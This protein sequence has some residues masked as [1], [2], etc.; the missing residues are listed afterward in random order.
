MEIS[1]ESIKTLRESTG[2]GIMDCR[3]SLEESGGD[4]EKAQLMLKEMGLAGAAKKAARDAREGLVEAYVH[5]GGRI[6][7]MVELNCETDFVS[8]TSDFK[9]VAHDV[10]MQVA[11]MA[12]LYITAGDIPE[13]EA[14]DPQEVCLM[15]Q[16][17]I[18]DSSKTIQDVVNDLVARV[19]ENVRVGRFIRYVL[20]Q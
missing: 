20:G 5:S 4:L 16:V 17:F 12:P 7:S 13:G 10:A 19:G 11:A 1:V 8:R 9:E 15:E 6:A 18:K 2:A 14:I 3:R